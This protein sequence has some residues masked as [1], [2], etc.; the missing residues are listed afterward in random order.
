MPLGS[1]STTSPSSISYRR[2]TSR[3]HSTSGA[4]ASGGVNGLAGQR[5]G[6]RPGAPRLAGRAPERRPCTDRRLR[7]F[8]GGGTL[9]G[10]CRGVRSPR[11]RTRS[12]GQIS[13]ARSSPEPDQEW[14]GARVPERDGAIHAGV[15]RIQGRPLLQPQPVD[16][17]DAFRLAL[18]QEPRLESAY[19]RSCFRGAATSSSTSSTP[20]RPTGS[21]PGRSGSTSPT[22]ATR[23]HR[24]RARRFRTR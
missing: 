20:S 16:D 4:R 5:R 1:R 9:A 12:R 6:R 22:S 8:R 14:R 23:P 7:V 13:I 21:W 19:R 17:Q 15:A 18:G 11:S 24:S 2:A 3:S 10:C